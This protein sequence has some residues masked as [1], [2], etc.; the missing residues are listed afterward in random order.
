MIRMFVVAYY[1]YNIRLCMQ[2][3]I[4]AYE[5]GA[6]LSNSNAILPGAKR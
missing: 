4:S 6:F 5:I 1:A 3:E 2:D